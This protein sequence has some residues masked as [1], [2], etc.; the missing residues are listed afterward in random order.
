MP[1]PATYLTIGQKD[2]S[3]VITN[4]DFETYWQY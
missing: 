1:Y 2:E 4:G 3:R